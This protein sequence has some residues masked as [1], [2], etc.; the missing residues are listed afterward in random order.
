MDGWSV[1]LLL[2]GFGLLPVLLARAIRVPP[3]DA[4][5]AFKQIETYRLV[6]CD[7]GADRKCPQGRDIVGN[8][9]RC[10]IWKAD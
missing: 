1:V 7:C 8:P 10:K 9:Y 5:P 4:F 6:S 3:K 2:L